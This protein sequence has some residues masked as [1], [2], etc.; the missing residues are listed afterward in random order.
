MQASGTSLL[1][2]VGAVM[3][4]L[5]VSKGVLATV[6]SMSFVSQMLH[7]LGIVYL[8]ELVFQGVSQRATLPDWLKA[9]LPTAYNTTPPP[10][11]STTGPPSY[12]TTPP[13]DPNFTSG[14]GS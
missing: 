9:A 12:N 14:P 3:F 8:A 7:I 6:A 2:I 5:W 4:V 11:P 13:P 1:V 10:D